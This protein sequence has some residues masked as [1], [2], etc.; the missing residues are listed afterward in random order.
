VV[1]ASKTT[2]Y[3]QEVFHNKDR[4]AVRRETHGWSDEIRRPPRRGAA[5]DRLRRHEPVTMGVDVATRG[6][7]VRISEHLDEETKRALW[8]AR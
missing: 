8:M 2:P 3:E 4:V 7:N 1:A 6:A 5:P